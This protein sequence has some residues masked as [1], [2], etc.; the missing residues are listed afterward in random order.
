M[1]EFLVLCLLSIAVAEIS[2]YLV[3]RLMHIFDIG[4]HAEHHRLYPPDDYQDAEYRIPTSGS[5]KMQDLSYTAPGVV[6]LLA[7]WFVAGL[8]A[9]LVSA[10]VILLW[11]R[12]TQYV[13][14]AFHIRDHWLERYEWFR[15]WSD[16]H[17][18]HH[19]EPK[20]FGII[21]LFLD[22][23]FRTHRNVSV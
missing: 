23:V 13:H 4:A 2:G 21:T 15:R 1:L 16:L 8:L 9:V 18:V 20:N 7:V 17:L 22:K 11:A 10:A 6:W 5:S 12:L 19:E 14:N 3:H